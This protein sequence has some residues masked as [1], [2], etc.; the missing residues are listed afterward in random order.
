MPRR[1]Y[2]GQHIVASGTEVLR[3][4]V[5]AVDLATNRLYIHD[6][7]TPGGVEL[8]GGSTFTSVTTTEVTTTGELKLVS[9]S[10]G[11]NNQWIFNTDGYIQWPSGGIQEGPWP[12]ITGPYA[13]EAAAIAAGVQVYEFWHKS[14]GTV[15]YRF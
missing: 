2:K 4:G 15:Y 5:L 9:D 14:D 12:G 1:V 11:Y 8:S 7:S 10:D 13:D 6:G 3:D